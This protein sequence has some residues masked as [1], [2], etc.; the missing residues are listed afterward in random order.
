MSR[1]GHVHAALIIQKSQIGH[2]SIYILG[3]EIK[4]MILIIHGYAAS[5]KIFQD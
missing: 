1:N 5:Q 2:L 4:D 3:T